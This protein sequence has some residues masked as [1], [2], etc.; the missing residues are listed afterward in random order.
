M[1]T[2]GA[3]F[4]RWGARH[5]LARRV[6]RA[7][8]RAGDMH[9][10]L[11]WDDSLR[12]DPYPYYDRIRERGLIVPGRLAMM[13]AHHQV[14]ADI[15][16]DERFA[17]G[18]PIENVPPRVLK[19]LARVRDEAVLGPLEPPSLLAVNGA[20]HTRLRRLVSRAFTA[21]AVERLS[22]RVEE[23]AT[24][25]LDD[26]ERGHR[27]GS[28][29]DL[30]AA[31]AGALPA[32][33]IADMLGVPGELHA[34]FLRWGHAIAPTLDA[35]V[36][37]G[38]YRQAEDATRQLNAWLHGHFERLRRDPGDG[39]LGGIVAL[40]SADG[41]GTRAAD[42]TGSGPT[43]TDLELT[44]IS[45]L[46]LAAG[47][48][49]TVNLIGNGVV[50]L[51]AH[52]DQLDALRAAPAGWRNAVEEI[53]RFDA[54][55][56]FVGRHPTVD[57]VVHGVPVP[58][59]HFVAIVVGGANRDPAVFADPHRFDVTRANAREHLGFS[60]GPHFCLGAALARLEGE[61]GLRL[62]FE[63]F[64]GVQIAGLPTRRPTRVLR[65]Y[66]HLPVALRA[67]IP[68]AAPSPG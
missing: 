15:L 52:P 34:T 56:Q 43:L 40:A 37:F 36:P 11:A 33:V 64:G 66:E 8:A 12:A 1:P 14:A 3:T 29:V 5:G 67:R 2:S 62:L 10:K 50:A 19:I 31:Y 22:G 26:L 9:A 25:L 35:G 68:A 27:D 58:R 45:G 60:A 63:R 32:L 7:G 51:L 13:T 30:V 47:F 16:R 41:T 39:I 4:V 57:T 21:R 46:L 17:V 23:I 49:T 53:L 59:H 54:P 44:S 61:I 28:P 18:F 24:T 65:G 6:I 20:D 48:E 38:V 55:V 42:G